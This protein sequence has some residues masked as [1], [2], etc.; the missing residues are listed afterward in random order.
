MRSKNIFLS[1]LC[2]LH[3]GYCKAADFVERDPRIWEKNIIALE[4]K[5]AR[6][7]ITPIEFFS[8]VAQA[9]G[10]GQTSE[11]NMHPF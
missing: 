2:L 1:F 4:E 5:L 9:F 7:L 8:L 11:E 10:Y 6:I 3:I